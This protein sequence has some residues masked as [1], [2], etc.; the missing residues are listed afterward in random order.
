M[1]ALSTT[2]TEETVTVPQATRGASHLDWLLAA[3]IIFWPAQL[4]NGAWND[5]PY[6]MTPKNAHISFRYP[7]SLESFISYHSL[8]VKPC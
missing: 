7:V 8:C 3:K 5:V 2:C 1:L 4:V 6:T